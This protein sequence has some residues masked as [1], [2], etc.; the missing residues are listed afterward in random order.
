MFL[1][2]K[3]GAT[4]EPITLAQAKQHLRVDG[5]DED[6]LISSLI[7]AARLMVEARTDRALL[8]QSWIL[9]LAP[10]ERFRDLPLKPVQRIVA[11]QVEGAVSQAYQTK[12][13][14]EALALRLN[15][16]T[17]EAEV[18]FVAGYG[19]LATQVPETL[20]QAILQLTAFWFENRGSAAMIGSQMPKSVQALL[21]PYRQVQL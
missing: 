17:L 10:S 4:L 14:G 7:T 6:G 2:L 12:K 20:R 8:T 18:E 16:P 21:A 13:R 1:S 5:S 9:H 15:D 19:D 3:T 11:V